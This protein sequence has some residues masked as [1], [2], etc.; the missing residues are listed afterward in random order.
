M[1]L[2]R[3]YNNRPQITITKSKTDYSSREEQHP[4]DLLNNEYVAQ[5]GAMDLDRPLC[6]AVHNGAACKRPVRRGREYCYLWRKDA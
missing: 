4:D 3:S 6:F 1:S 2:F 5:A